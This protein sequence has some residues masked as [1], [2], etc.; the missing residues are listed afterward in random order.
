MNCVV[1]KGVTDHVGVCMVL[2]L[3]RSGSS[4]GS[5]LVASNSRC[6]VIV[7]IGS[8]YFRLPAARPGH[9][10]AICDDVSYT[11]TIL[12]SVLCAQSSWKCLL[13]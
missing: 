4:I 13:V 1:A 7:V 5:V 10:I 11:V 8:E 3:H 6:V 12:L 2:T 9:G